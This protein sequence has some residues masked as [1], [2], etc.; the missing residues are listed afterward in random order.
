MS[1]NGSISNLIEKD[2]KKMKK[3]EKYWVIKEHISINTDK[4]KYCYLIYD[5]IRDQFIKERNI[6][7]YDF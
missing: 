4:L 5:E 7:K 1:T 2:C 6:R 3:K